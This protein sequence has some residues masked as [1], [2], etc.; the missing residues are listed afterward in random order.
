M[1]RAPLL[2]AP[3]PAVLAAMLSPAL[4]RVGCLLVPKGRQRGPQAVLQTWQ[5]EARSSPCCWSQRVG[6]SCMASRDCRGV[7]MHAVG[8]PQV[9]GSDRRQPRTLSGLRV[10]GPAL[11]VCGAWSTCWPRL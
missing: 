7:G 2:A 9:M 4:Q 10:R 3:V 11:S 8:P 6:A 5:A 1:A